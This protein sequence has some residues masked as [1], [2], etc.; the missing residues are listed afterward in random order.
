MKVV[1]GLIRVLAMVFLA[2]CSN[3][4]L[5]YS[6]VHNTTESESL[7]RP[8]AAYI[9]SSGDLLLE[10]ID[11]SQHADHVRYVSIRYLDLAPRIPVA[12]RDLKDAD[13]PIVNLPQDIPYT[14]VAANPGRSKVVP[15][16]PQ[17]L[18]NLGQRIE[19]RLGRGTDSP[20]FL[21]SHNGHEAVIARAGLMDKGH[22][23]KKVSVPGTILCYVLIVPAFA[24]D[25]V[26]FPI[27]VVWVATAPDG[28]S[29]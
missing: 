9:A 23:L 13:I 12:A 27:Q 16:D 4:C 14:I 18:N 11:T 8:Q 26:T 20:L 5:S 28:R 1:A 10:V 3:G 2:A 7:S 25:V 21:Y 6:L 17:L 24:I 19:F 22:E 29:R 15:V